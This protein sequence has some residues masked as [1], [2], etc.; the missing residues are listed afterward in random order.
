VLHCAVDGKDTNK[1]AGTNILTLMEVDSE[2]YFKFY[3]LK[4][5]TVTL[6]II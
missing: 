5:L 2:D 4:R 1:E 3:V 6:T